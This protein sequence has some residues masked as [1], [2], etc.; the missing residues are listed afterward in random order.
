MYHYWGKAKVEG[1]H[2]LAYHQLDVAAVGAIILENDLRLRTMLCECFQQ[3]EN[4][5]RKF[6]CFI[7]ALHDI[8]KFSHTFQTLIPELAKRLLGYSQAYPYSLRHDSLGF[9]VWKK[10]IIQNFLNASGNTSALQ[11][12]LK[13]NYLS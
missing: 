5:F 12:D 1:F 13:K 11:N 8:G 2:L 4:D 10:Y 9:L 7:L 3:Q 6:F